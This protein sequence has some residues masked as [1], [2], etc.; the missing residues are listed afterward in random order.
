MSGVGVFRR[1][2]GFSGPWPLETL[3]LSGPRSGAHGR[4][5]GGRPKAWGDEGRRRVSLRKGRG[6]A[7][8]AEHHRSAHRAR[9]TAHGPRPT[10]H[11]P[12]PT[13]HDPRPTTHEPTTILMRIRYRSTEVPKIPEA[14]NP[15]QISAGHDGDDAGHEHDASV[16]VTGECSPP[17]GRVLLQ[18]NSRGSRLCGICVYVPAWR[19]HRCDYWVIR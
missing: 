12:R 4:R 13:T 17:I 18:Y 9:H 19:I 16:R 3:S 11:G 14:N 5:A 2:K 10:A 7:C 6:R 1:I 15:A 8:D